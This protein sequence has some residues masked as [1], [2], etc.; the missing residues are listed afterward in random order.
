MNHSWTR[1]GHTRYSLY[2]HFWK[3]EFNRAERRRGK[4]EVSAL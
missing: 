1:R 2:C 4:R 3:R